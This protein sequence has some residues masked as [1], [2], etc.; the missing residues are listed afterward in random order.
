MEGYTLPLY[1]LLFL[2]GA[3]IASFYIT[4]AERI[5]EYFYGKKRKNKSTLQKWKEIFGTPSHCP[6]CE[7]P[8]EKLSL[9]PNLGYFITRGK[10]NHCD[11]PLKKLYP[12]S[13]FFLGFFLCVLYFITNNVLASVCFTILLG[14]LLI[15]MIT[16]SEK[17]ILDYE[18]LAFILLFGIVTKFLLYDS[19]PDLTNLYVL[20]GFGL[21]YTIIYFAFPG[22]TGLGDVLFSPVFAFIVGH[23]YWMVYLNSAYVLAL[24]LTLVSKKRG[25]SLKGKKI[26]MGL[27][28]SLGLF[29]SL[30]TELLMNHYQLQGLDIYGSTK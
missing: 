20:L 17:F 23:P 16:D 28:F 4:L 12:L 13:E 11:M 8:V 3:S 5:L 1:L 27:Y 22:G 18:N 21:F 29:I 24:F 14:H 30:T 10:C 25:E 15:S 26:P 19:I 7:L 9:I 6:R 2:I